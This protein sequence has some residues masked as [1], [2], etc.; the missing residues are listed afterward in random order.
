[1]K[2]SVDAQLARGPSTGVRWSKPRVKAV[3]EKRVVGRV[4]LTDESFFLPFH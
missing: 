1:M 2:R 3:T 4:C